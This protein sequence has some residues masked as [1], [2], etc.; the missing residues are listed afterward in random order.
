MGSL[1]PKLE[2]ELTSPPLD[3]SLFAPIFLVTT[4][5][6]PPLLLL[7]LVAL[8]ILALTLRPSLEVTRRLSFL[9]LV[10]VVEVRMVLFEVGVGVVVT[11]EEE[12]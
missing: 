11:V 4:I 9:G 5:P 8:P 10:L 6:P 3:N 1:L 12:E 7:L 2:L